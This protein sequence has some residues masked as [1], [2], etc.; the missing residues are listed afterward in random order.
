MQDEGV[1]DHALPMDVDS[2]GK[3]KQ[4]AKKKKGG[5]PKLS[6]EEEEEK[7][8]KID[9]VSTNDSG[10]LHTGQGGLAADAKSPVMPS[11]KNGPAVYSPIVLPSR[12]AQIY[13]TQMMSTEDCIKEVGYWNTLC[14]VE[15][16]RRMD[17]L[18]SCGQCYLNMRDFENGDADESTDMPAESGNAGPRPVDSD[19]IEPRAGESSGMQDDNVAVDSGK[20]N[21]GRDEFTKSNPSN[22]AASHST[23]SNSS[24]VGTSQSTPDVMASMPISTLD[25]HPPPLVKPVDIKGEKTS[26]DMIVDSSDSSGGW[27]ELT[28]F[29]PSNDAASHSTPSNSSNV[30]TFQ[31]T[32]NVTASTPNSTL[33]PHP[34]SPVEPVDI[35]GEK[36]SED[37]IVDSSD[38]SGGWDELTK[39]NPSDDAASHSTPSNPSDVGTSQSPD[40]TASTPSSTPDPGP[41]PLVKPVDIEGG[42]ALGDMVVDCRDSSGGRDELTNSKP[43]NHV[44]SHF[45]PFNPSDVEA[46]QS[47]P[48][49]MASMPKASAAAYF[50][51]VVLAKISNSSP[52]S[53]NTHASVGVSNGSSISGASVDAPSTLTKPCLNACSYASVSNVFSDS[54]A[55][56]DASNMLSKP[57]FSDGPPNVDS[58]EATSFSNELVKSTASNPSDALASAPSLTLDPPVGIGGK[59][60][61][62]NAVDLDLHTA[63]SSPSK[64]F[65]S[66]LSDSSARSSIT[67]NDVLALEDTWPRWIQ[68]GFDSLLQPLPGT[69]VGNSVGEAEWMNAMKAWVILEKAFGFNNPGGAKFTYP[70]EGHPVI[71]H[72]WF[73]N[74]KTVCL[75][76]VRDYGD[77]AEFGEKW[78][79]WWSMICP[80]WQ[81]RNGMGRIVVGGEGEGEWDGFEQPGQSGLLSVL[82][83]LRWWFLNADLDAER[84]GSLLALK[85]VVAVMED[86]AYVKGGYDKWKGK[87]CQANSDPTLDKADRH[88]IKRATQSSTHT[89][90]QH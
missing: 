65:N 41:P 14:Q 82:V 11:T 43:S 66:T 12:N 87:K 4:K 72:E 86:I 54:H 2:D 75:V 71:V 16:R 81:E 53:S 26:E 45:T 13:I 74:R 24:D 8:P 79:T 51:S 28:K 73:K 69:D 63:S 83:C 56:G 61:S 46:S 29:N 57:H 18:D 88:P 7:K 1:L 3:D 20:G 30:R 52:D 80:E 89:G 5:K 6:K 62:V 31:S 58:Q 48:G 68:E 67:P 76:M 64:P 42:K 33:D 60:V 10:H 21:S 44:A 40:V 17:Y 70:M 19:N 50:V 38:S 23:L 15:L 47:T 39:S 55:S 59:T 85:D 22:D 34:P 27:D 25:P 84:E 49:V 78:W 9:Q 32:L 36:T 77:V 37:M 90:P 35:E